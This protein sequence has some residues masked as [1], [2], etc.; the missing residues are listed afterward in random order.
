MNLESII[1]L[2]LVFLC[3]GLMFVFALPQVSRRVRTIRP[4]PAFQKLRRAIGVSVEQGLR[5][6]ISLGRSSINSP[7]GA[8]ALAG[9]GMLERIAR[10]SSLSDR[11]P[12]ATSGDGT[13]SILSQDTLRAGYRLSNA[14]ELYDPDRGRL[15][16]PTPMS[17]VAGTLPVTYGEHVSTHLMIGNFGPEVAL[18]AEAAEQQGALT[19]AASDSLPA[20]AVLYAASQEPLIGE[21]L[22]A[23]PAYLQAGAM[24]QASLRAQ[25]VL[26]W[27]LIVGL[28]GGAI[29]TLVG[30]L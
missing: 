1:G 21:E 24:H 16:G 6:H 15:A 27:L 5:L 25:D 22:F 12:V 17:Y 2:G 7:T 13:L 11:P 19:V 26:R 20:Q 14:L 8:S 28:V 9:L 18:L 29:L 10:S 4:M 23:V 3:A 30:V